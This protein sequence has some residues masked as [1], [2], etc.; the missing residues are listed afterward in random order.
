MDA[1]VHDT[2]RQH[3]QAFYS[4]E[5]GGIVIDP[6]MMAIHIDDHMVRHPFAPLLLLLCLLP[7]AG[8]RFAPLL[9]ACCCMIWQA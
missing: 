5:L 3:Y 9:L 8:T 7:T 4:S 1:S 2:A 6:A